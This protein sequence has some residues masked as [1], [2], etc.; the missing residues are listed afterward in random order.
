[1]AYTIRKIQNKSGVVYQS[2]IRDRLGK[3]IKSK[4]F[5]SRKSN[6]RR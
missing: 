1:M 6:R 3:Q 4:T 2:V 5:T